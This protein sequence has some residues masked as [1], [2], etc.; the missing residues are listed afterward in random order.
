VLAATWVIVGSD[1]DA[2][3]V[4]WFLVVAPIVVCVIPFLAPRQGA[5]IGAALALGGW[6]VLAALSIGFLLWPA[7]AA[8]IA[9]V[10]SEKR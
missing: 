1:G 3:Q 2:S 5:R 8:L 9:A 6:C 4:R 10:V 7:L